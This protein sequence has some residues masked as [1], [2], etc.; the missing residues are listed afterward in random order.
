MYSVQRTQ[1]TRN[2]GWVFSFSNWDENTKDQIIISFLSD[3][4]DMNNDRHEQWHTW[5]KKWNEWVRRI[6]HCFCLQQEINLI[7]SNGRVS[8]WKLNN[9]IS[10][11]PWKMPLHFKTFAFL[12]DFFL[13]PSLPNNLVF[14]RWPDSII[15]GSLVADI[16]LIRNL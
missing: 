16:V 10:F 14:S 5:K 12:E 3:Q 6:V 15:I 13:K 8:T 1:N 9:F 11:G 2:L 7:I 4:K